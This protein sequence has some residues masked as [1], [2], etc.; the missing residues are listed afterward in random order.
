L[1]GN[2]FYSLDKVEI[3]QLKLILFTGIQ[4]KIKSNFGI[5]K[6]KP[7][8]TVV[9]ASVITL[10]A[11]VGIS[12][13]SQARHEAGFY[14]DT[15]GNKP[16]TVYQNHEGITEPWIRWTSNYFRNA[17]YDPLTRCQDVSQRLETYHRNRQLRFVTT[18]RMNGQNVICTANKFNGD[19]ENLILTLKPSENPTEALKNLFAWYSGGSH[20]ENGRNRTPYID[21]SGRLGT[22][23]E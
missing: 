5:M 1:A 4:F 19:C 2:C 3:F 14:C 7:L 8:T 20:S 18:G 21:V 23:R 11:S 22:P 13:P 15:S 6:L 12:Q 17:G 10:G 9:V 16:V